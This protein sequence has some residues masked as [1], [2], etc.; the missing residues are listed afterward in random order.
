MHCSSQLFRRAVRCRTTRH[1]V[2]AP[3]EGMRLAWGPKIQPASHQRVLK[4]DTSKQPT[5]N[6]WPDGR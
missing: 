1:S 4:L 3:W 2:I 6:R 5:Q